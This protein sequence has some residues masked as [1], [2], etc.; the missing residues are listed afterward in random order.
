MRPSGSGRWRPVIVF[1]YGGSWQSGARGDYG[2]VA[3]RL[4]ARGFVVVVPDYRL[5]PETVYPGFVEDCAGGGGLGDGPYHRL[6]RGC[7]GGVSA[8]P[9]RGG[10]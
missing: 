3:A 2:F 4:V 9:F 7:R 6:W 5:Y 10:V 1:F 8:G